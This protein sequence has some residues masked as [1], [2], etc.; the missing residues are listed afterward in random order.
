MRVYNFLYFTA[1]ILLPVVLLGNNFFQTVGAVLL[2]NVGHSLLK[3]KAF[4]LKFKWVQ[5]GHWRRG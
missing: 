4:L 1:N 3:L 2:G 5:S